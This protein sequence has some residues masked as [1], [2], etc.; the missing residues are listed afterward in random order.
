MFVRLPAGW[1]NH[2]FLVGRFQIKSEGQIRKIVDSGFSEVD[3]DVDRSVPGV[4]PVEE[5]QI[6]EKV[7]APP[8]HSF[9]EA[10]DAVAEISASNLPPQAK[11]EAVYQ[12]SLVMVEELFKKPTADFIGSSKK[13]VGRVV[14]LI[15]ADDDTA[16]NLLRVSSHDQYTYMHSVNVGV[17]AT[18]LAKKIYHGSNAHN[19]RELGAGFFLH[20]LGKIHVN[21]MI[22]TKPGKLTP[23][24]FD[25]MRKHPYE[26]FEILKKTS[27]LSDECK[28]IT[29]QHHERE[30]GTG[31]PFGLKGDEIHDYA[32]ICSIAD[33]FDALTSK[34]SYREPMSAFGAL[35]IMRDEM[36]GHFQSSMLRDF[37]M[38]FATAQ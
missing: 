27:Q 9:Q 21:Q 11:A 10:E 4:M 38:L 24:E 7:E 17:Y 20:D 23:A 12:Q 19:M 32:R 18:A 2:P 5:P 36:L 34:R 29:L 33:V 3:I 13:V 31:Y 37:I 26:S 16:E 15:L 28:V 25:E 1:L 22:I 8:A 35:Q 30:D 14:D 6:V